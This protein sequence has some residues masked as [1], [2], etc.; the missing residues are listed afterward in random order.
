MSKT[1]IKATTP[2]HCYQILIANVAVIPVVTTNFTLFLS[3]EKLA[4]RIHE[5]N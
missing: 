4:L 3:I 2:S 5:H 1:I